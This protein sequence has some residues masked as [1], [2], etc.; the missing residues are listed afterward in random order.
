MDRTQPHTEPAEV[1]PRPTPRPGTGTTP[2][3]GRV[4]ADALAHGPGGYAYC[5]MK[6]G[7]LA[8]VGSWGF[9]RMPADTPDHQGVP[10]DIDTR[11]NL[12]SVSKTVTATAL[13]AMVART[14]WPASTS[15]SGRSSPQPCQG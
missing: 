13:F 14:G 10:F 4:F 5:V 3:W 1:D 15:R 7:E 6:D 8:S 12:A 2:Q 11:C 9:A